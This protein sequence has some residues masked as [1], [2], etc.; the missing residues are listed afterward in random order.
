MILGKSS[1]EMSNH[2]FSRF[3]VARKTGKPFIPIAV[4]VIDKNDYETKVKRKP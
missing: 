3:L 1:D 4:Q 2:N